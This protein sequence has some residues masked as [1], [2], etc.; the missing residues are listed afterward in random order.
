M[1]I[2]F[3]KWHGCR[4]DFL[5]VKLSLDD[6]II[7]SLQKAAPRLCTRDGSGIGADGIIAIGYERSNSGLD[8]D[9]IYIINSDGSLAANCGNGLR[10]AA[11]SL[12]LQSGGKTE[13]FDFK[14]YDD[15]KTDAPHLVTAEI[16]RP[17]EGRTPLVALGMGVPE[18]NSGWPAFPDAKAALESLAKERQWP[19]LIE[20]FGAGSIG[21]PHIVVFTDEANLGHWQEVGQSLQSFG[22]GINVHLVAERPATA[23]EKQEGHRYLGKGI[24]M[25]Y[26]M[27]IYERGAGVTP[28]CGSGACMVAAIALSHDLGDRSQWLRVVMQ[29]GAV[30]LHQPA[31]D[32]PVRMAGPADVVF[33][34]VFDL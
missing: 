8:P 20:E 5:L 22:N 11:M 31:A 4:N 27:R 26:D 17:A 2:D 1:L 23:E 16:L 25:S 12:Y 9:G 30:Y 34:G 21:N 13:H 28:A 24:D 15:L 7:H 18:V 3:E 6:T 29:G 33:R 10:C 32:E 19:W 14:I